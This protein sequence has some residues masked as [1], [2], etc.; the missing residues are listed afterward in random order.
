[1]HELAAG[2]VEEQRLVGHRGTP[3]RAAGSVA[4]GPDD[5]T[6]QRRSAEHAIAETL[7]L[8]NRAVVEVEPQG[9]VARKALA[10]GG[11]ARLEPREVRLDRRPAVGVSDGATRAPAAPSRSACAERSSHSEGRV[12]VR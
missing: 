3:A 9:P 4:S 2:G 12:E 6:E 5:L 7:G 11:D 1:P 8:V 10:S